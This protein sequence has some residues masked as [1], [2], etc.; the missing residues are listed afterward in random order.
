[1]SGCALAL[2]LLLDASGSVSQENYNLQ[3][4]GTAEA[5]RS[6]ALHHMVKHG[7]ALTAIGWGT[8]QRTVLPWR[9]ARTAADLEEAAAA[10][11]DTHRPESGSTNLAG[12]LTA[13]LASFDVAPCNPE[14]RLID[15]SGDGK[16]VGS[17]SEVEAL[18]A[19]AVDRGVEINALPIVTEA[20]PDVAD[21]YR[22]HVTEPASGFTLEG[23]W[24]GFARSIR[25]KLALEIA[26]RE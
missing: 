18:V 16:H 13:G 10:L 3:R 17:P 6:P 14:R 25:I 2:V 15:V 4:D 9:L 21:W 7:L 8:N 23:S 12:A 22:R 26:S 5:L 11:A 20:E 1:M 24:S 19:Q